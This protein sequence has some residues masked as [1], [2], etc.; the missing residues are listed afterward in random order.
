MKGADQLRANLARLAAEAPAALAHAVRSVALDVQSR[1]QD[2]CPVE[3]G[4]L[5]ASAHTIF[6]EGPRG[7]TATVVFN[8]TTPDGGSSYALAQHERLDFKHPNPPNAPP[9]GAKYLERALTEV[10]RDFTARIAEGVDRFVKE[11]LS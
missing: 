2:N 3:T 8:A 9:R 7:V 6:V 4:D 1:A 10:E 11:R 5:Q